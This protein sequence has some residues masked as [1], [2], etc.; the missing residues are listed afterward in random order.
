MR[1]FA[2][3]PVKQGK[4]SVNS[5]TVFIDILQEESHVGEELVHPSSWVF[6][7]SHLVH[8][9]SH[10]TQPFLG[11]FLG[12]GEPGVTTPKGGVP[13]AIAVEFGTMKTLD[14]ELVLVLNGTSLVLGKL[15]PEGRFGICVHLVVKAGR[16]LNQLI[17]TKDL[18]KIHV[19]DGKFVHRVTIA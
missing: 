4:A 13:L 5:F 8:G 1:H 19:I 17:V 12:Y 9:L 15:S 14:E 6:G 11:M 18:V 16:E 2:T 10:V 7:N 3:C